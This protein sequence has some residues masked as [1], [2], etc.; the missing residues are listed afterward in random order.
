MRD[1][2]RVNFCWDRCC[3]AD[4][5]YTPLP[6]DS[7][8]P[9]STLA[10]VVFEV[11][12]KIFEPALERFRS[13]RCQ[14]AKRMAGPEKLG[15]GSQFLDITILSAAFFDGA[16]GAFAPSQSSPARSTPAA[17]FL[18]EKAFQIPHHA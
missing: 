18:C 6:C 2:H 9:A 1:N 3:A 17:G 12:A 7:A 5:R 13:A 15:L 16:E 11:F 8:P 14:R 10:N 4:Y